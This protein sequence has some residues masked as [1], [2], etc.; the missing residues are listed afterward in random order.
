MGRLTRAESK[1]RTRQA[2]MDAAGALFAEVGYRAVTVEAIVERAGFT[3]G[4]F[5]ANFTDKADLFLTLVEETRAAE[6]EDAAELMATTPD[7]QK[8]DA[9]QAWYDGLGG[10]RPWGLAY[11]EFWPEA[12]RNP[13]HRAR[14]AAR[15]RAQRE[16]VTAMA[17]RWCDENGLVSPR[18]IEELALYIVALGEGLGAHREI[19]PDAVPA[20]AFSDGMAFVW[21]GMM[22]AGPPPDGA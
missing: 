9:V 16:A 15:N 21:F 12:R 10:H 22:M 4:A 13:E 20:N 18:P 5:Y 2:L 3:R 8:L 11:A 19:D 1:A 17:Q 7:D 14:L 6:F